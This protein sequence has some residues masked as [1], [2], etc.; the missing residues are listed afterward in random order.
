MDK[1][2]VAKYIVGRYPD[3]ISPMKLQKLLFY[4]YAWQLIA[5]SKYF[6]AT[7]EAWKLGPVD[8]DIYREYK[9]YGKSVI[10]EKSAIDIKNKVLDFV[11][12]SYSVF[13]A[14][15]LSKTTHE[16]KPWKEFQLNG[17]V[18]SDDSLYAYYSKQAF[19]KN[20]PL[21][22]GSIYYPPK[23]AAHFAYTFDMEKEYVPEFESLDAYLKSFTAERDR[24]NQMLHSY[25][26]KN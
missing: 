9:S 5:G 14:L 17:G 21:Q 18:I 11:L 15:E 26:I 3:S 10:N 20:F 19:A 16:E 1:F 23:T 7:F 4:S 25:G 2:L 6:E 24:L 13:S 8:P 12:D 22:F